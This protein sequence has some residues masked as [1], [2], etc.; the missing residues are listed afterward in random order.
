MAVAGARAPGCIL[1]FCHLRR[2][3]IPDIR[4]GGPDLMFP[5]MKTKLPVRMCH[6][7]LYTPGCAGAIRVNKEKMSKSLGN[8][9][10]IREIPEKYPAEVVRFFWCPATHRSQV[11]YSRMTRRRGGLTS[12]IMLWWYRA[13]EKV[14]VAK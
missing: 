9:F 13:S 2:W 3:V 8:F 10:T 5:I 11:D 6:L 12:S 1:R 4:G 14:D 7:H